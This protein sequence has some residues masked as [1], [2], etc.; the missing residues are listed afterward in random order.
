MRVVNQH[1]RLLEELH[2]QISQRHCRNKTLWY[3]TGLGIRLRLAALEREKPVADHQ[4]ISERRDHGRRVLLQ[5][6][7]HNVIGS[8]SPEFSI[9]M[10]VQGLEIKGDVCNSRPKECH[11]SDMNGRIVD[12]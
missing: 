3:E 10:G 2:Q 4:D 7:E 8:E 5:G 11:G 9:S 1:S 6:S 12:E